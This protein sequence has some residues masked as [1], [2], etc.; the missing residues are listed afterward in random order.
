MSD[1]PPEMEA[2]DP[3]LSEETVRIDRDDITVIVEGL[4]E[5]PHAITQMADAVKQLADN[6]NRAP[7]KS[8]VGVVVVGV[9]IVNL[10]AVLASLWVIRSDQVK[11]ATRGKDTN[12]AV[13]RVEDCLDFDGADEDG[14]PVGSCATDLLTGLATTVNGIKLELRC[15][16]Q[17]T[18]RAF[19]TANPDFGVEPP[20]VTEECKA[21]QPSN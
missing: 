11:S 9:A 17:R 4:K 5:M 18:L 16:A 13:K 6:T 10:V 12:A 7:T 3:L 19:V 2:T 1:L 20:P 21:L 15:E 8:Y 14:D